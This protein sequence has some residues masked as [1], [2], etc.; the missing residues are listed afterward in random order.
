MRHVESWQWSFAILLQWGMSG[1]LAAGMIANAQTDATRSKC[2][3]EKSGLCLREDYHIQLSDVIEIHLPFSPEYDETATVQPDGFI[4]MHEA[5]PVHA[6]GMKVTD[7][8]S[9]IA[10]VYRPILRDPVVSIVLKDF[11][12]PSF[13]AGGE[14]GHPG[15]YELRSNI[16]LMQAITEAGGLISE[17]SSRKQIILMRPEGNSMYRTKVVDVSALMKPSGMHEDLVMQPGDVIYVPQKK[18]AKI[19]RFLPTPSLG[20]Y[21]GPGVF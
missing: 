17:R 2:P 6:A 19:A 10:Q 9:A 3:P 1:Y 16:T 5:S 11:Q 14:V 21:L 8:E 18:M 12:K 7:L 20:A 15:R 4:R 13:F